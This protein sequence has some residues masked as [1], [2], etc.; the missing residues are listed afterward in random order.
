MLTQL[1]YIQGASDPYSGVVFHEPPLMLWLF[2]SARDAFA[3]AREK[4]DMW[5]DAAW[6]AMD[7]A[8]ALGGGK[9]FF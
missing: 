5:L 1:F 8:T 3:S 9:G 2:S 4:E 6:I 7:L